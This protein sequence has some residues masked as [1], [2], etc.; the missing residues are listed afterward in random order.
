MKHLKLFEK[1]GLLLVPVS[2]IYNAHLRASHADRDG[3]ILI[4]IYPE[5]DRDVVKWPEPDDEILRGALFRAREV[6]LIADVKAV[7]LPDGREFIIDADKARDDRKLIARDV[8]SGLYFD[9][10]A[11]E[12]LS[13]ESAIALRPG[14]SADDFKLVWA[15]KIDVV[16]AGA[17]MKRLREINPNYGRKSYAERIHAGEI[18]RYDAARDYVIRQRRD[19]GAKSFTV[20]VADGKWVSRRVKV[21]VASGLNREVT[22]RLHGVEVA[23]IWSGGELV[24]DTIGI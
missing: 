22:I 14:T 2:A 20:R 5:G 18:D 10:K 12:A 15:G 19:F 17:E 1:N 6:G 8:K 13:P 23:L 4:H 7:E 3:A 24:I 9:G 11:F 21:P 16:E